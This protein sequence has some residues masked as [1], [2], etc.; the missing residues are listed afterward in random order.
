[1][2]VATTKWA[3]DILEIWKVKEKWGPARR[4]SMQ[5]DLHG[6]LS[7]IHGSHRNVEREPTPSCCFRISTHAWWL[8]C[9]H[10]QTHLSSCCDN[11]CYCLVLV[12]TP[13]MWMKCVRLYWHLFT[14]AHTNSPNTKAKSSHQR[15]WIIRHDHLWQ[16]P[17]RVS[18]YKFL[19]QQ[20][21]PSEYWAFREAREGQAPKYR[22]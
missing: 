21:D 16:Q 1:M 10:T 20:T 19:S 12:Q 5:V 14:W 8:A 3:N 7:L 6:G 4:L 22:F 13:S 18:L 17:I 11:E 15:Q 2:V 9:V